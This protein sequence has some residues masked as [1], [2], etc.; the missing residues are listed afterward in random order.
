MNDTPYTR[1]FFGLILDLLIVISLFF[2]VI[3]VVRAFGLYFPLV[4]FL[5]ADR[6]T[7]LRVFIYFAGFYLFYELFF[8]A[9]LMTT[10]GKILVNVEDE[11]YR[12]H[13]FINVVLRCLIK[14][15]TVVLGPFTI[16]VSLAVAVVRKS[17][18]SIHDLA[19]R[20]RVT[21]ETRSPRLIG[22]FFAA[23]ALALTIYFYYAVLKG[24]VF[25]F[26]KLNIP[27]LYG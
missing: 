2:G 18:Q 27:T 22:L 19:A 8:S 26:A 15:I 7:M 5:D 13:T 3:L 25:D 16:A 1:R 4:E 17:G 10:P 12:G 11:Y 21:E 6:P 24:Q 14:T 23:A 20:T 9:L